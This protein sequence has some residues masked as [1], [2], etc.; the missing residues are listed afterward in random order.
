MLTTLR[1]LVCLLVVLAGCTTAP[2]RAT[3]PKPIPPLPALPHAKV[4]PP[5][6]RP[7]APIVAPAQPSPA[8]APEATWASLARW[9]TERGLGRPRCL[10]VTPVVTYGLTAP[11]GV[12]LVQIGSCSAW[13]NG[14]EF[15][16]GFA[17][18]LIDG[19]VWLRTLDLRKNVEPLLRGFV[20]PPAGQPRTIV[21]DPGHG[22]A[23]P[24]AHSVFNGAW[25]KD[26][27]LD[28]AF[29]LGQLLAARGW[30]VFLTRTNDTDVP[31]TNRVAFAA[32]C[33]ANLFLSLHFNSFGGNG[34]GT[35]QTGVETYCLTP[36]GM[37][38]TLT[39][40][41]PDDTS[42]VFPGNAHDE[43]NVQFALHVHRAL[44]RTTG[45]PDRGVR[46][47]RFMTVLQ[48]QRCSAALLEGGF[49]SNPKEAER[50][51]DWNFRQQMAEALADALK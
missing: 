51:A 5:P 14:V 23:S 6:L 28:C 22:G 10:A 16:L 17:P 21:I 29:R 27:T 40:G 35:E 39:R 3:P 46:R 42:L 25:E 32:Q 9:T 24:G 11:G 48:G 26:Y 30:R 7:T 34:N 50:I 19:D 38:S 20:P 13:W 4:T 12:L 33:G 31:L 1:I 15:R 45:L 36:A 47:A 43:G 41:Y 2:R 8:P 18:Q 37:P 49:L 44:L